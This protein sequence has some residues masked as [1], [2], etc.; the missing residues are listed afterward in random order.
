M[1]PSVFFGRRP[2]ILKYESAEDNEHG[3][4]LELIDGMLVNN[5]RDEYGEYLSGGGDEGE[6]KW[7]ELAEGQVYEVEAH[8]AG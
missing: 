5:D 2:N 4:A 7:A 8:H 3:S 6:H 1:I